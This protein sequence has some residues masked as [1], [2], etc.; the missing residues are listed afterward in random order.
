MADKRML[1]QTMHMAIPSGPNLS[2]VKCIQYSN[3]TALLQRLRSE[4][5]M[6]VLGGSVDWT[7]CKTTNHLD[8]YSPFY[9]ND[10]IRF[11]KA[12]AGPYGLVAAAITLGFSRGLDE[13]Q[14]NDQIIELLE[15]ICDFF[16][17][18]DAEKAIV[19]I[20]AN[21]TWNAAK[22][23]EV[24]KKRPALSRFDQSNIYTLL[25]GSAQEID[26]MQL[27]AGS[28]AM[29]N[30]MK[31]D[32]NAK[33]LSD[34]VPSHD[35][36]KPF[37]NALSVQE[38]PKIALIMEAITNLDNMLPIVNQINKFFQQ[39]IMR[40]ESPV[41]QITK[42]T[43]MEIV[44]NMA[45]VHAFVAAVQIIAINE[46]HSLGEGFDH[47][48]IEKIVTELG[49]D[50]ID[51]HV[52]DEQKNLLACL[53]TTAWNCR[54]GFQEVDTDSRVSVSE[55]S[56]LNEDRSKNANR[57]LLREAGRLLWQHLNWR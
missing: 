57:D 14:I 31:V 11:G 3:L 30:L 13:Q 21:M 25:W 17:L 18:S 26:H 5:A 55:I 22:D 10:L 29:L 39:H 2:R 37:V 16:S 7:Y 15:A 9:S 32:S 41:S 4:T 6:L 12:A 44:D 51:G 42:E 35:Y 40:N 27:V 28:R 49:N 43:P 48:A 36:N 47:T 33:D 24:T 45:P 56:L 19:G 20:C 38:A 50:I 23:Y 8:W 34:I 1:T 52:S 54:L 53:S 46:L